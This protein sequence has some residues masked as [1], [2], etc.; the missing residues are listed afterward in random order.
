MTI[1]D[2]IKQIASDVAMVSLTIIWGC[3]LASSL[4]VPFFTYLYVNKLDQMRGLSEI[5]NDDIIWTTIL[6]CN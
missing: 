3:W 1:I 6:G 2:N 4:G 5:E